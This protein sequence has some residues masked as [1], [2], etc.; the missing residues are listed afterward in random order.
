[1]KQSPHFDAE[2]EVAMFVSNIKQRV[3]PLA[4][5]VVHI[6]DILLCRSVVQSGLF[7]GVRCPSGWASDVGE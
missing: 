1:M 3:A 2:V 4:W 5:S 6:R 7:Y